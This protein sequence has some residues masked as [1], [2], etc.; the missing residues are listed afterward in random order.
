MRTNMRIPGFNADISIYRSAIHYQAGVLWNTRSEHLL[1][2]AQFAPGQQLSPPPA[3]LAVAGPP[4]CPC[5]P[6]AVCIV[7]PSSPTGCMLTGQTCYCEPI[8]VPCTGCVCPPGWTYCG[9]LCVNLNTFWTNCG[10]CGHVC[11]SNETCENGVCGC[12]SPHILCGTD[13]VD[14]SSDPS[15]CG[16]CGNLCP[17]YKTCSNG[18]CVCPAGLTDCGTSCTDLSGD[19]G[20]CGACGNV[21]AGGYCCSGVCGTDCG[22]KCFT[23]EGC[24]CCPGTAIGLV[25][26]NPGWKCKTTPLGNVCLP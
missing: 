24:T 14:L 16:S 5:H 26:C 23:T 4:A 13:C 22:S 10:A 2:P 3:Q 7:D 9:K 15:N 19:P 25:C 1:D 11:P 8:G 18:T 12:A 6:F 20:N 21:C 17:S